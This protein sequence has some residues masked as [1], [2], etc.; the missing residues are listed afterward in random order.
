MKTDPDVKRFARYQSVVDV[1]CAK[2]SFCKPEI[3]KAFKDE[4]PHFIGRVIKELM[5]DGYLMNSGAKTRP[6]YFWSTKKEEFNPGAGLISESSL[7]PLSDLP[8]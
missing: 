8:L 7:R 6:Q 2:N 3:Y 5:R 4:K 1:L